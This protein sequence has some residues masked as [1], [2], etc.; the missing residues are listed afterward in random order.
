MQRL[1]NLFKKKKLGAYDTEY[2]KN[3]VLISELE[4]KQKIQSQ[5]NRIASLRQG[6]E[7]KKG[8]NIGGF[9]QGLGN[10]GHNAELAFGTALPK[11]KNKRNNGNYGGMF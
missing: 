8:S 2:F 7:G 10:F 4:E 1:F 11:K 5:R 9:M 3:K 6:L